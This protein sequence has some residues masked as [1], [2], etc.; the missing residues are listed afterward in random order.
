MLH[1]DAIWRFQALQVFRCSSPEERQ[2]NLI[3]KSTRF[4][5]IWIYFTC[6][7]P[8]KEKVVLK[9]S[10]NFVLTLGV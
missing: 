7:S 4:P 5:L 1:P 6:W 9:F 8:L 3:R 10:T 2:E